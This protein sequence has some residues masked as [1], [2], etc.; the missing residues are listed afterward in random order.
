MTGFALQ[1]I[2]L[3]F[4]RRG[5][6]IG[7]PETFTALFLPPR[8]AYP[9]VIVHAGNLEQYILYASSEAER[10]KWKEALEETKNLRDMWMDGNKVGWVSN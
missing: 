6:F 3:D 7:Q 10:D 9:F 5:Q 8:F 1:P 2:P 4:L